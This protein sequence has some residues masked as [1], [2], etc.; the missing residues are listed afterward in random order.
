MSATENPT[1]PEEPKWSKTNRLKTDL[2]FYI[3]NIDKYL[4][5]EVVLMFPARTS[6]MPRADLFAQTRQLLE[7][8]S[9]IPPEEQ[10][11]HVHKIV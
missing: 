6:T 1:S 4:V 10:S 3:P 11:E 5:P 2:P 8:Y 7:N 9:K